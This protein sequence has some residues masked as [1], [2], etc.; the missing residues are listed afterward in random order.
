MENSPIS[1]QP[2]SCWEI[3]SSFRCPNRTVL[4]ILPG[5]ALAQR[6]PAAPRRAAAFLLTFL[7]AFLTEAAQ[8]GGSFLTSHSSTE[9]E[10]IGLL[11]F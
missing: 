11:C 10:E 8:P 5:S 9:R 2:K 4:K 3:W 1:F 7:R 6:A